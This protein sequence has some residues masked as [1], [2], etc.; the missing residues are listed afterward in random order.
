MMETRLS[1]RMFQ[2]YLRMIHRLGCSRT[3]QRRFLSK[4]LHTLDRMT[5]PHRQS[6]LGTV[7]SHRPV[8][9]W[10]FLLLSNIDKQGRHSLYKPTGMSNIQYRCT[11]ID[12]R[13]TNLR[14]CPE[15]NTEKAISIFAVHTVKCPITYIKLT[16]Q[17]SFVYNV[18]WYC[19]LLF[20]I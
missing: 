17:S 7:R 8:Q 20:E 11:I 9:H 16:L 4:S 13:C 3:F 1:N 6:T 10:A 2:I 15:S 5:M 14:W 19:Y 18:L 12:F